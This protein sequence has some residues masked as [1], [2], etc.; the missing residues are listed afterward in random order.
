MVSDTIV[1]S[2]PGDRQGCLFFLRCS[3]SN[4]MARMLAA[5]GSGTLRGVVGPA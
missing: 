3:A 5:A 1:L 4:V 2:L